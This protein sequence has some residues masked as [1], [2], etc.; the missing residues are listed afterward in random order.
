M[1]KVMMRHVCF[2]E[3]QLLVPVSK[4]RKFVAEGKRPLRSVPFVR[5]FFGGAPLKSCW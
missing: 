3:L 4:A 5:F 1:I 2:F